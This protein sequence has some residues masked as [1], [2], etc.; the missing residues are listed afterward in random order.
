MRNNALPFVCILISLF[1]LQTALSGQV[2]EREFE[3]SFRAEDRQISGQFKVTARREGDVAR[4]SIGPV[5]FQNEAAQERYRLRV[6]SIGIIPKNAQLQTEFTQKVIIPNSIIGP[7]EYKVN[8]IRSN[9]EFLIQPTS[10]EIKENESNNNYNITAGSGGKIELLVQQQENQEKTETQIVNSNPEPPKKGNNKQQDTPTED[11]ETT[12]FLRCLGLNNQE[13]RSN[14]M[15]SFLERFG[16]ASQYKDK[17]LQYIIPEKQFTRENDI[18]HYTIRYLISPVIEEDSS[19]FEVVKELQPGDRSFEYKITL[20]LKSSVASTTV[21]LHD[22]NKTNGLNQVKI[23]LERNLVE[24]VARL[25]SIAAGRWKLSITGGDTSTFW[26]YFYD[27]NGKVNALDRTLEGY[28]PTLELNTAELRN[29][30]GRHGKLQL[31]VLQ[32]RSELTQP[33]PNPIYIPPATQPWPYIIGALILSVLALLLFRYKRIQTRKTLERSIA[34]KREEKGLEPV[35][36]SSIEMLE[37][38]PAPAGTQQ[39]TSAG[40]LIIKSVNTGSQIDVKAIEEN[41]FNDILADDHFHPLTLTRHWSNTCITELYL[42]KKS[43]RDIDTFLR[44]QRKQFNEDQEG[45]L[46]EIGGFL[47]GRYTKTEQPDHFKVMLD[48]FVAIIPEE[49]NA[50]TLAFST[51]SLVRELGDAQEKFPNLALV[52][53]FHTHPGHGLFLSKPDLT[54][55]EGFFKEKYQFAMEIDTLSENLDTGFFTRQ[56][57]GAMNNID[58]R[59]PGTKWFDWTEIEKLTRKK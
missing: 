57:E 6:K 16:V 49:N 38:P 43:I 9:V 11:P 36:S 12:A 14:A 20:R 1:A 28:N 48:A 17:A 58:A 2:S 47:L 29:G 31:R 41:V 5:S 10:F 7:L 4:L 18:F 8:Q 34:K 21:L 39:Y 23:L 33:L 30:W 46:P 55:H 25:D 26:L 24:F 52:G 59:I 19:K 3:F 27:E 35:N 56:V 37:V 45:T 44:H 40:K 54:I 13:D 15:I 50:Y 53:W 32:K 51:E 42:S 22:N